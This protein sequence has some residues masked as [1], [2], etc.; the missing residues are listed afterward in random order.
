MICKRKTKAFSLTHG[1]VGLLPL[2]DLREE[3]R[4]PEVPGAEVKV[5]RTLRHRDL[6]VGH[7]PVEGLELGKV[8]VPVPEQGE[9]PWGHA[10]V[11]LLQDA[12]DPARLLDEA[13]PLGA[14]EDVLDLVLVRN[15]KTKLI[16]RNC[17][18]WQKVFLTTDEMDCWR[19]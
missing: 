18:S 14:L 3:E 12:D 11:L 15:L 10:L 16:V 7:P 2:D 1:R 9:V 13:R 17:F 19:L 4:L 6:H 5:L 8:L